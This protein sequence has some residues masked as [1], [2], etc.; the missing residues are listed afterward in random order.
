VA[1]RTFD[2]LLSAYPA[3]VQ[4]VAGSARRLIFELLPNA[5]ETVDRTGPYVAYG[6]GPGYKG[7][8]CTLILSKQG[9]KLG[10]SRGAELADRR[11]LLAG[12]GKIHRYIPLMKPDDVR[13]PGVRPLLRSAAAS[14]RERRRQEA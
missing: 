11:K 2:Q 5:E 1:A 4:A 9:V 7:V 10:L 8:V 12:T 13:Q 14:W 6:Y 3:S